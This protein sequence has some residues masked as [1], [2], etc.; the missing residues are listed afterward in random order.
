VVFTANGNVTYTPPGN[1]FSGNVTFGYTVSDG[2]GGT[3]NGSI[4][5]TVTSQVLGTPGDDGALTGSTAND[6]IYGFA[7]N[8]TIDGRGGRDVI[9]A[10]TG[11]DTILVAGNDMLKNDPVA[12]DTITGGPG[13]DT[14]KLGANASYDAGQQS[15]VAMSVEKLDLAGN[16]LTVLGITTDLSGLTLVSTTGSVQGDAGNNTIIGTSG[17]DTIAGLGGADTLGGGAGNDI[18]IGGLGPDAVDGGAGDDVLRVGDGEMDGDRYWGGSGTDTLQFTS[19]VTLTTNSVSPSTINGVEILDMA[20]RTLFVNTSVID[21]SSIGTVVNGGDIQGDGN[22]NYIR[23]TGGD[24]TIKGGAGSDR[25]LGDAGNDSIYG[26]AGSDNIRGGL[27]NDSL[28]G[29]D[30]KNAG[31]GIGDAFVFDTLLNGATNVDTIYAFEAGGN[32]LAGGPAGDK[33]Y[34]D[35]TIFNTFGLYLDANEFVMNNGGNAVDAN[36]RILYDTK[37]GTLYYDPDGLGGAGK[38]AF[39]ILDKTMVGTLDATDFQVGTP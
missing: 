20:K 4:T 15:F 1:A 23:G 37:T 17:N 18:L 13:I 24:D 19:N 30:S 14:I 33:I 21:L 36:S 22:A 11:D 7:G 28:Y 9:D 38:V 34:L 32:G 29:S 39:A 35:G 12:G 27:G 3:A 6:F 5:V 16:V 26:G 10:G 31:D 25:L 2:A 8:D